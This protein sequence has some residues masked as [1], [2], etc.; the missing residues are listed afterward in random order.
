MPNSESAIVRDMEHD[1]AAFQIRP[2]SIP[3]R[4]DLPQPSTETRVIGWD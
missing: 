4:V 1:L 3:N 2:D